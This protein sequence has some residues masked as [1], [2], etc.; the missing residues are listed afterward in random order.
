MLAFWVLLLAGAAAQRPVIISTDPGAFP[1]GGG[2]GGL[3]RVLGFH[4]AGAFRATG[5]GGQHHRRFVSPRKPLPP[6][7]AR[8][9][10][11]DRAAVGIGVA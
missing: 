6:P 3:F 7:L 10:R 4:E 5:Q 8:N 11:F 2:G 9:R 1:L